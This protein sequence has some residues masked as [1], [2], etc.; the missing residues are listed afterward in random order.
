MK[1]PISRSSPGSPLRAPAADAESIDVLVIDDHDDVR[2][3]LERC[4]QRAGY[5]MAV[6][7]DGKGALEMLSSR[8]FQLV[9]TD[10]YMPGADGFEVIMRI[11]QSNPRPRLIAISG[12]VT[13]EPGLDLKTARLLGCDRVMP[14]P[15]DLQ[16]FTKIVRDLIGPPAGPARPAPA[17]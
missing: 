1:S 11:N 3:V 5:S 12:G 10:I 17:P 14:K 7:V 2:S 16:D 15:F 13:N 8:R 4:L 6:C 9:V